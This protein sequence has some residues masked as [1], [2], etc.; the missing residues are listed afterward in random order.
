[1]F[2]NDD[3]ERENEIFNR[4]ESELDEC[5]RDTNGNK[6]QSESEDNSLVGRKKAIIQQIN[7]IV[8]Q[9]NENNK[10][11]KDS[12]KRDAGESDILELL[13]KNKAVQENCS[14]VEDQIKDAKLQAVDIEKRL[15][16]LLDPVIGEIKEKYDSKNQSIDECDELFDKA[17]AQIDRLGNDL[18]GH[19]EKT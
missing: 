3:L 2:Q 15:N 16:S 5:D 19:I 17:N 8:N 6:K 14:H 1:M 18:I 4:L 13:S 7:K 9:F 10:L 11:I 12:N